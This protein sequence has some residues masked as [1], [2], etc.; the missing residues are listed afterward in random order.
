MGVVGGPDEASFPL[1]VG[2]MMFNPEPW[3]FLNTRYV[4]TKDRWD[5]HA[6]VQFTL[7]EVWGRKYSG[8]LPALRGLLALL[9]E[10]VWNIIP[11][12]SHPPRT[13]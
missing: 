12:T 13:R 9:V 2:L 6:V 8:A 5:L 4:F 7:H 3:R 10:R 11:A 1:N